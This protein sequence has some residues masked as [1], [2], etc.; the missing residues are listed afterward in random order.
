M[1]INRM[2][3]FDIQLPP[4]VIGGDLHL[5]ERAISVVC[6]ASSLRAGD[7][8]FKKLRKVVQQRI[9]NYG[10]YK[11]P[12]RVMKPRNVTEINQHF[13]SYI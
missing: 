6:P 2:E 5:Q 9:E 13:L 11:V 10:Y 3:I 8:E 7:S 4:H 12:R 1:S